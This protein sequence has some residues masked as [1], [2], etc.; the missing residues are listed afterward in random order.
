MTLV[1][2]GLPD[3]DGGKSHEKSWNYFLGMFLEQ[4]GPA[5]GKNN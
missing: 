2:S 1:H 5:S 4:F 3:M